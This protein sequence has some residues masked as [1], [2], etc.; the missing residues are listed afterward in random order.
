MTDIETRLAELER[1]HAALRDRVRVLQ[2][3]VHDGIQT[4]VSVSADLSDMF[5]AHARDAM[6]RATRGPNRIGV[7]RR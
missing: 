3:Q 4:R 7:Y 6:E 1:S 2:K 5:E